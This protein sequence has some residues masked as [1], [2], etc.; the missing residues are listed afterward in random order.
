[1]SAENGKPSIGIPAPPA[2]DPNRT[3]IITILPNGS[4]NVSVPPDEIMGRFLLSKAASV[5]DHIYAART[6][7]SGNR[8]IP[9]N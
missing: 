5:A 2:L 6:S 1:M 8:I 9:V 3:L 4:V 7:G